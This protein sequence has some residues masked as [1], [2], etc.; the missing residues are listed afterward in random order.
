MSE[1]NLKYFVFKITAVVYFD[2]RLGTAQSKPW[3]KCISVFFV[4]FCN[5]F[6][7]KLQKM[8]KK[9]VFGLIPKC[10]R[11]KSAGRTSY[12]QMLPKLNAKHV[13]LIQ[14]ESILVKLML[15]TF[16]WEILEVLKEV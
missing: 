7:V 5:I 4:H 16:I 15:G 11:L 12:I 14:F 3:L 10:G 1:T 9:S 8:T 6:D 13:T 2:Q